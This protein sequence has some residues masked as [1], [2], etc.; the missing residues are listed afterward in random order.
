MKAIGSFVVLR[1]LE[2]EVKSKSGLIVTE[3]S[4]NKIRYKLAEVLAVGEDVKELSEGDKV[5]FDVAAASDIRIKTEKLSVVHERGV[6]V[7][8]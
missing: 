2:E 1:K 7:K 3:S 8:V 4:D 5:Y 6:V